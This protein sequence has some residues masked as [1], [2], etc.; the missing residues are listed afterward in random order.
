MFKKSGSALAVILLFF[1]AV[2][3]VAGIP[4]LKK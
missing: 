4:A 1:L 2:Y 3:L